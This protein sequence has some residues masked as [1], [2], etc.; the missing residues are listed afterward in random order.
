M[1]RI[2]RIGFLGLVLSVGLAASLLAAGPRWG[3]G[4]GWC[5]ETGY[6]TGEG[7]QV[8]HLGPAWYLERQ[9]IAIEAGDQLVILGSLVDLDGERVLIAR[10]V[11]RGEDV[12]V[13]RDELGR[14]YWAGWRRGSGPPVPRF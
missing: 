11:T 7:L 1:T 13:L 5:T 9:D 2:E 14:P 4:G 6:G 8:V 12:L 3:R 10:E